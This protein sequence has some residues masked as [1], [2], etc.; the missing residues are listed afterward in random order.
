[1]SEDEEYDRCSRDPDD[2]DDEEEN[3]W[4]RMGA[5]DHTSG[6]GSGSGCAK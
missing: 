5:V 6:I 4:S 3:V 2:D 1:M